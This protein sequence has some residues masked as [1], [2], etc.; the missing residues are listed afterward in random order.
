M[1]Q[2]LAFMSGSQ[3]LCCGIFVQFVFIFVKL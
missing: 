3:Q 2:V 1:S